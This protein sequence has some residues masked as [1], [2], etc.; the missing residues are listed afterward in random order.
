MGGVSLPW[1]NVHSAICE[2]YVV[3]CFSDIY[4]QLEEGVH[5]P[6]VYVHSIICETYLVW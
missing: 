4:A 2:K 1:V 5:L 6:S 3:Q